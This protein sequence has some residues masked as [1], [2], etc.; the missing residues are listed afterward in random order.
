MIYQV[1]VPSAILEEGE[2]D[3]AL[4]AISSLSNELSMY[5]WCLCNWE[6]PSEE[7]FQLNV[8]V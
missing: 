6:V 8:G 1:C 2:Q 4:S 5:N 7:A 3:V